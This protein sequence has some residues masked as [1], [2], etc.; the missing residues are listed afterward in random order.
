MNKSDYIRIRLSTD[1]KARIK[2]RAEDLKMSM[3]EYI[4]HLIRKDIVPK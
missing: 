1:E 2:E 3:S 4:L